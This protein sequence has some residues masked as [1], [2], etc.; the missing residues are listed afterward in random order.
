MIDIHHHLLYETDDG[1]ASL[2]MSLQMAEMAIAEGITHIV[3]TPHASNHWKFNPERNRERIEVLRGK[4]GDRIQLGLGCDFHM[5][6]DNVRE[7]IADPKKYSINGNGYLLV[8]LPDHGI[9]QGLSETFYEMRMAGLIPILTHP[10]RN[11]TLLTQP[12]RMIPWM[13]GGMLIQVT[14][15]SILGAFGKAAEKMAHKLLADGWVS[16]IATDAHDTVRRPPLVRRAYEIVA[17]KY[18]EEMARTLFVLNPRAVFNGLP[19]PE[20]QEPVGVFEDGSRNWWQK[21]FRR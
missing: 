5:T 14:A 17:A 12:Q 9:A 7:A 16:F 2:E 13:R 19:V 20:P 10:E 11:M 8:E 18:G 3:C 21:L 1:A 15:G 6:Y 4:L